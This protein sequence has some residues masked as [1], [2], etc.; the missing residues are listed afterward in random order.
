[1]RFRSGRRDSVVEVPGNPSYYPLL[2]KNCNK[3]TSN[4]S[5]SFRGTF[6]NETQDNIKTEI[7][8]EMGLWCHSL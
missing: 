5:L 7:L 3:E 6:F 4:V 1:M 2:D 8:T